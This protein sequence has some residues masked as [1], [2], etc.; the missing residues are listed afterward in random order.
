MGMMTKKD[1]EKLLVQARE[2]VAIQ[3]DTIQTLRRSIDSGD[4]SIAMLEGIIEQQQKV[5]Q[6]HDIPVPEWS[7]RVIH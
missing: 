2:V 7:P 3:R 6:M 4:R 1:L 5:L